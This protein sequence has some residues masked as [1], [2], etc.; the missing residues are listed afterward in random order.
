MTPLTNGKLPIRACQRRNGGNPCIIGRQSKP[1][2]AIL[3]E[4]PCLIVLSE[5]VIVP[6]SVSYRISSTVHR[7]AS[8]HG[9]D[10][11]FSR[12]NIPSGGAR[13]PFLRGPS[14]PDR[15]CRKPGQSRSVD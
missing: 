11:R 3:T 15:R 14:G 4:I 9:Y 7:V 13:L 12:Q 6:E 2:D 8:S 5:K 1:A 10:P